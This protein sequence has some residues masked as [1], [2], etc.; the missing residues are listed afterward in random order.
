MESWESMIKGPE[1]VLTRHVRLCDRCHRGQWASCEERA[2]LV[3]MM[4]AKVLGWTEGHLS[5]E[6]GFLIIFR[7]AN[8]SN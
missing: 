8:W 2:A 1:T 7:P 3:Q 4:D 5:R 6:F